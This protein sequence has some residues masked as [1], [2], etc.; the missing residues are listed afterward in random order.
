MCPPI[1]TNI[2]GRCVSIV[3]SRLRGSKPNI[4]AFCSSRAVYSHSA[5]LHL[6]IL[7]DT[8]INQHENLIN[9]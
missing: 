9:C 5:S 7:L 1:N 8:S 6:G 4:K 3:N 2:V